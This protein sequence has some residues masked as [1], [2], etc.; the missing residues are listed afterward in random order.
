LKGKLSRLLI[1]F[2]YPS[3]TKII[4]VSHGVKADLVNHYGVNSEKCTVVYNAYNIDALAEQANG[5]VNYPVAEYCVGI[6]RLVDN[7]NFELLL[8][9]IN[10][11]DLTLP[12]LLL[13]EGEN[14]PKLKQQ[15]A[16]LGI[17][18]RVHFMGYVKNP[19]PYLKNASFL[20]STSNAEGFPNGIAESICLS[21]PVLSTN[22][23]SGPAEI[24]ASDYNFSSTSAMVFDTGILVPTN[25]KKEVA[26]GLLQ[27]KELVQNNKFSAAS[28]RSKADE[29]SF[30]TLKKSLFTLLNDTLG[31]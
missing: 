11:A 16:D 12:L 13:G 23:E 26:R 14:E 18:E 30:S 10:E 6:G 28:L 27:I 29:F 19:Y 8:S 1:R 22:C 20:V 31:K 5:D 24:L 25:N 2:I 17:A 7:K 9:A 3:A 4:A 15:A 21:T